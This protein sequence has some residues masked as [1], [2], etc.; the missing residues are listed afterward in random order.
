M[1]IVNIGG[2]AVNTGF[3]DGSDGYVNPF[4]ASPGNPSGLNYFSNPFIGGVQV[5]N[6]WV[7]S[8]N[9]GN[10]PFEPIAA[11]SAANNSSINSNPFGIGVPGSSNSLYTSGQMPAPTQQQV[12]N[13]PSAYA[14]TSFDPARY[15]TYPGS[16]YGPGNYVASTGGSTGAPSPQSLATTQSDPTGQNHN[17]YANFLAAQSP[18]A[19]VLSQ[20]LTAG[21]APMRQ[22]QQWLAANV[23][24]DANTANPGADFGSLGQ[25]WSGFNNSI[26]GNGTATP[27]VPN[28]GNGI[29]SNG[30]PITTTNSTPNVFST[31]G[32]LN[33]VS[34]P[35]DQTKAQQGI[36]PGSTP[37][38]PGYTGTDGGN[39]DGYYGF[40][41]DIYPGSPGWYALYGGG[42]D[43]YGP[44]SAGNEV[45]AGGGKPSNNNYT[46][47]YTG[48]PNGNGDG[49]YGFP[50]G[51]GGG[52][53]GYPPPNPPSYGYGGY[54]F[55]GFGGY[56]GYP[57]PGYGFG[58]YGGSAILNYF[59][60][61]GYPLPGGGGYGG[62]PY[63]NGP[64]GNYGGLPGGPPNGGY[65][66]GGFPG[67]GGPGTGGGGNFDLASF[68]TQLFSGGGGGQQQN[69]NMY[70]GSP[71]YYASLPGGSGDPNYAR[72]SQQNSNPLS[73]FQSGSATSTK[74]TGPWGNFKSSLPSFNGTA[75]LWK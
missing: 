43:P 69:S 11:T 65:G 72:Y 34:T 49:Y 3:E 46:P 60:P 39:G 67:A 22:A 23:R 27:G 66:T 47:S 2:M 54:P 52:G 26:S 57:F 30:F 55:P 64:Y 51:P 42:G 14:G 45:P 38:T 20:M 17:I 44:G 61:G 8:G 36:K 13:N 50:G 4:G 48:N 5:D 73:G 18:A 33:V 24:P 75:G 59:G 15:L 63:P 16:P 32:P 74:P 37:Y 7:G 68:F 10:V 19:L 71:S 35:P 70:P 1:G 31:N 29:G 58:G 9:P 56:G 12:N 25:Y 6:P 28:L 53:Y 62:N 40:P 41:S 21:E